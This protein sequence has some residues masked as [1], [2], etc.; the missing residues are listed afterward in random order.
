MT[1]DP[2]HDVCVLLPHMQIS[3]TSTGWVVCVCVCVCVCVSFCIVS[4]TGWSG[5]DGW[6]NPEARVRS[7]AV[8]P[9]ALVVWLW[10]GWARRGPVKGQCSGVVWVRVWE[11][12]RAHV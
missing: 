1:M 4:Q 2:R 11:V 12:G 9:M 6:E 7:P 3:L 8:R 5:S 10:C